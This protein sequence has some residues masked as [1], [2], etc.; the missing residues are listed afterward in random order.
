M[1][2]RGGYGAGF[3]Q[4]LG[5]FPHLPKLQ[6][7][8]RRIWV[9]GVSVGEL[10]MLRPLLER[11]L[12]DGR[13][14]IVLTSTS[15]SGLRLAR[16]R[17]GHLA[18]VLAFPID[19]WPFSLRAWN[20][21]RPSVLLHGDGELWPEHL[22]RARRR[23]VPVLIVNGRIS[24]DSFR[25]HRRFRFLSGRLWKA[26]TEIYPDGPASADRLRRLHVGRW[27][28][29]P[30]GNLKCDRPPSPPLPGEERER[31]LWELGL[32]ALGPDGYPTPILV[33]CSTWP[34]EEE[35]LLDVLSRLRKVDPAWRLLLAPRHGERREEL[36]KLLRDRKLSCH[37]RSSGS[38]DGKQVAVSIV[39]TT[40]ELSQLVRL[41][42]VAF[43]GKTLPPNDGGQSP[44]DAI[45]ASICAV[46]G[47]N[48]TNFRDMVESLV[49]EG[50][51]A[52]G[53]SAGEVADLLCELA[54]APERRRS[55]EL[56]GAN[57]L[58]RNGGAAGRICE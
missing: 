10:Q 40:G 12:A 34:G 36:Q 4:R 53:K 3:F 22:H 30:M 26:V 5:I 35:F 38:A 1:R 52:L 47:P 24:A 28:I 21:I 42:T 56:A 2:R 32:P 7:G 25:R 46:C 50:A 45:A 51:M 27:K 58:Q 16:E 20:R 37:L 13:Y 17:Y 43:V 8:R 29:L 19:F 49:R 41:G 14:D 23:S 18:T 39:D 44:L 31:A 48:C 11:L 15:S 55:M 6:P 57:W 9:H 33:G 54:T